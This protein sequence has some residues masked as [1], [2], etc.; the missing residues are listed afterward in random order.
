MQISG[1][2]PRLWVA[3]DGWVEINPETFGRFTGLTDKNGKKIFEGDIA[4]GRFLHSLP[5]NAVVAFRNGAFGLLWDRAGAETFDAFTSLC[6]I[7]YEVIG[8]I[9]DNPELLKE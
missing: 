6:N 3:F 1:Q 9:H 4:T 8:N 2:N 5:I 7:E